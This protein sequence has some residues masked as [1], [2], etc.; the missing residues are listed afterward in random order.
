MC[1]SLSYEDFQRGREGGGFFNVRPWREG[2]IPFFIWGE[3]PR[4]N[5]RR[6]PLF[7]SLGSLS[8]EKEACFRRQDAQH[9]LW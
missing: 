2:K 8:G 1:A 4:R 3:I 9:K 7:S 6:G 5:K